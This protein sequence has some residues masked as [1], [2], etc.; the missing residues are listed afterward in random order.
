MDDRLEIKRNHRKIIKRR[1]NNKKNET[2][3]K[4]K[5]IKK[6]QPIAQSPPNA[7]HAFSGTRNRLLSIHLMMILVVSSYILAGVDEGRGMVSHMHK[8]GVSRSCGRSSI[9]RE[10][11]SKRGPA[12]KQMPRWR[13]QRAFPAWFQDQ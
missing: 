6:A 9:M 12:I 7:T 1:P 8:D 2:Q 10:H 11:R 5:L 13:C 3:V 4:D